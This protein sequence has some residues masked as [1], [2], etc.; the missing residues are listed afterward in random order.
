[1]PIRAE[2]GIKG[3]VD[4]TFVFAAGGLLAM[5]AVAM[6]SAASPL[7]YYMQIIQRHFAAV[8]VG[9][10]AFLF[11]MGFNYQIFEDQAKVIYA[12]IFSVLAPVLVVGSVHK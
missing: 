3:R 4:W 11:G 2:A 8:A 10:V 7:P 1:M 6:L 12:G 9:G 5:G